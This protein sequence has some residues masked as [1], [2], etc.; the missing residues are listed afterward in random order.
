MTLPAK[1]CLQTGGYDHGTTKKRSPVALRALTS[2]TESPETK[3]GARRCANQDT[4]G[5]VGLRCALCER[6]KPIRIKTA[7][8]DRRYNRLD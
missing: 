5:W 1:P 7:V 2:A 4:P 3:A 8:I 6:R